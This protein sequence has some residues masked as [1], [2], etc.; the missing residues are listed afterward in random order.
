MMIV[1]PALRLSIGQAAIYP[2]A[3]VEPETP[4]AYL[5]TDLQPPGNRPWI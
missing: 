2:V 1:C 3:V 5:K 4:Q